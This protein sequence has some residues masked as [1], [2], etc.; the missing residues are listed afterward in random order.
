MQFERYEIKASSSSLQFNF[1]STGPK[2]KIKKQ[3]I[4]KA[5]K[6]NPKVFN[7]GFG[8]VD[9]SGDINDLTVTD[10]KDSQKILATVAFAISI[11][12]EKRPG[13]YVYATGS[14]KARSRLYRMGIANN[15]GNILQNFTVFAFTNNVWEPFEKGKDYDEFLIGLKK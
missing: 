14:T 7:I 1:Y 15:L 3:V 8:D 10:N 6:D 12:L 2:G 11:F 9:E 5:F 4:F 13:F